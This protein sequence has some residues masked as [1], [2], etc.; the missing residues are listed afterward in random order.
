MRRLDSTRVRV[1]MGLLLLLSSLAV[2]THPVDGA[3]EVWWATTHWPGPVVEAGQ[4]VTVR[5][6]VYIRPRVLIL[7]PS[8]HLTVTSITVEAFGKSHPGPSNSN[9]EA[10]RDFDIPIQVPSDAEPGD[11]F[12]LK[13]IVAGALTVVRGEAGK[14]ISIH[15]PVSTRSSVATIRIKGERKEEAEGIPLS[16]TASLPAT[17]HPGEAITGKGTISINTALP[18]GFVILSSAFSIPRLGISK[19]ALTPGT[20][21][22]SSTSFTV[23]ANIPEGAEPG[24]YPWAVQITAEREIQLGLFVTIPKVGTE[25]VSVSGSFEIVEPFTDEEDEEEWIEEFASELCVIATAAF[26]SEMHPH[27]ESMR[28][29]RNEMATTAFTGRN[30]VQV[31]NAWYYS[32]SPPIA[33]AISGDEA[34]RQT[35]RLALY[36]LVGAIG[37]SETTY[38]LLSF[39]TELAVTASILTAAAV[40]GASYISPL[41]LVLAFLPRR[42]RARMGEPAEVSRHRTYLVSASLLAASALTLVGVA[43]YSEGVNTLG[44]TT[45]AVMVAV[46]A[47]LLTLE[48]GRRVME[49]MAA[50]VS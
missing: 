20:D 15:S 21:F 26:G 23:T 46:S 29:L 22:T 30:F 49:R 36:P 13:T 38:N 6:S 4:L 11:S 43:A 41:I 1:L 39:N 12:T 34:L 28:N 17:A 25:S 8:S 9:V 16:L 2:E 48:A 33:K 37:A 14:T 18:V 31:F 35:A 27:V 32:W 3:G 44:I 42:L 40:C 7:D 24:T 45:L 10:A 19:P 50:V 47:A 5:I